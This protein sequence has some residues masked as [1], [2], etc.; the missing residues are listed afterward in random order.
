MESEIVSLKIKIDDLN[1]AL[2]HSNNRQ[3]VCETNSMVL[4]CNLQSLVTENQKLVH[5][6]RGK[7]RFCI[8]TSSEYHII[9]KN[10]WYAK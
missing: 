1:E 5:D 7:T 3:D 4:N 10:K 8:Q 2:Q 6:F 9:V